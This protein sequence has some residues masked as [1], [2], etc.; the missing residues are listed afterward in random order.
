MQ[1]F[2]FERQ[3]KLLMKP[4]VKREVEIF[5]TKHDEEYLPAAA[6]RPGKSARM[7]AVFARS[8]SKSGTKKSSFLWV[9]FSHFWY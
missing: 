3:K 8:F 4:D 2:Y 1:F 5:L 7:Q 6:D 9:T